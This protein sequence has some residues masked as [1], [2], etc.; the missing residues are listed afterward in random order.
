MKLAAVILAAGKGT[1]MKSNSQSTAYSLRQSMLSWV[2]NAVTAAGVSKQWLWW[3]MER[4]RLPVRK[5]GS[6]LPA[7]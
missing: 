3:D 2:I 1:R 6:R 7:G 4:S 5:D